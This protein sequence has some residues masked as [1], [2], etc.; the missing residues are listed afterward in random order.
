MDTSFDNADTFGTSSLVFIAKWYVVLALSPV[1]VIVWFVPTAAGAGSPLTW[2][3]QLAVEQPVV[4]QSAVEEPAVEQ[5][6]V[7]QSA[8]EQPAVELPVAEQPAVEQPAVE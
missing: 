3:E 2:V 4:E 6:A 8:V 5:S 1:T 7:E